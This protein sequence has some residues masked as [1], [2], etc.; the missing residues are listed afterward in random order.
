MADD[1]FTEVLKKLW[2]LLEVSSEFSNLVRVG[3]RI[4]LWEGT[5]T[6]DVK[7]DEESLSILD[8]PM[9]IIEPA[10]GVMNPIATSTDGN[11]IQTYRIKMMDGNLLLH[12]TYFPLKW[13][14][15]KAL[16]SIDSLLNLTYVRGIL[17]E[18]GIDERNITGHPGWNMG[19]DIKVSMWWSRTL[20]K[21]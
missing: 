19:I 14:I 13:A 18:D 21:A 11:F 3:N 16:A 1:P 7:S 6:A 12:K 9:V 2:D 10:G 4:K 5:L 17:I 15:F 8:L 20:L